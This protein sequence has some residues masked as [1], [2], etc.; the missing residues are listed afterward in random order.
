VDTAIGELRVVTAIP[1][2]QKITL[3]IRPEKVQLSPAAFSAG[4]N[5][6][7]VRIAQRIYVGAETQY[8]LRAGAQS[9]RAESMNV[10]SV[11]D[12]FQVGHEALAYLPPE[13]L[14][15]LDD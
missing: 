14:I 12:G 5:R 8:E 6:V 9:L 7:L 2:R 13:A 11:S 1:S 3:A 15:V 4:K 10:Q